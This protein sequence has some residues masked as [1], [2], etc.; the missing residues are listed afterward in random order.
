[1]GFEQYLTSFLAGMAGQ[2]PQAYMS[3]E[4]LARQRKRQTMVEQGFKD[5]ASFDTY[6]N[7]VREQEMRQLQLESVKGQQD[8]RSTGLANEA[9]NAELVSLSGL[10]QG[11]EATYAGSDLDSLERLT[12]GQ[13]KAMDVTGTIDSVAGM[14]RKLERGEDGILRPVSN[15]AHEQRSRAEVAGETQRSDKLEEV[16]MEKEKEENDQANADRLYELD[17]E[18]QKLAKLKEDRYQEFTD[19]NMEK[20]KVELQNLRDNKPGRI[21]DGQAMNIAQ[22]MMVNSGVLDDEENQTDA[23]AKVAT[24][25][26]QI[27]HF[28]ANPSQATSVVNV[29]AI[30][31]SMMR[32]DEARK[33]RLEGEAHGRFEDEGLVET[34]FG[35]ALEKEAGAQ[36]EQDPNDGE[37]EEQGEPEPSVPPWDDGVPDMRA[38]DPNTDFMALIGADP[39]QTARREQK[40]LEADMDEYQQHVRD[41]MTAGV[42]EEEWPEYLREFVNSLREGGQQ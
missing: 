23:A 40:E 35:K 15:V 2:P 18:K 21:S 20:M 13:Q 9:K 7:A 32:M 11:E 17:V 33:L 22:T 31:D 1:M 29:D 39:E 30:E 27:K 4:E 14:N 19:L 34:V 26:N 25:A 38:A 42:P 6:M 5:E 41:L 10:N 12:R 28:F 8:I 24:L 16:Q 37:G 3:P 36:G